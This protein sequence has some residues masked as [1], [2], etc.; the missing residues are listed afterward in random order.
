M[1][2]AEFPTA[3]SGWRGTVEI[4]RVFGTNRGPIVVTPFPLSLLIRL[5]FAW[6]SEAMSGSTDSAAFRS[7]GARKGFLIII[8]LS[9]RGFQFSVTYGGGSLVKARIDAYNVPSIRMPSLG[10]LMLLR[11]R[12]LL[13]LRGLIYINQSSQSHYTC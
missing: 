6:D 4:P 5:F 1:A 9:G 3:K 13:A 2:T 11:R 8:E 7:N 12:L 10:G